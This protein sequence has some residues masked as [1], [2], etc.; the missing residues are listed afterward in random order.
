MV[1]AASSSER[2][3]LYLTTCTIIRLDLLRFVDD[4]QASLDPAGP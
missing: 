3:V 1:L 4:A 2:P